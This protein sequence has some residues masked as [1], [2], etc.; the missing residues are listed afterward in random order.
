MQQWA[1]QLVLAS[2]AVAEEEAVVVTEE[3][4]ES[5]VRRARWRVSN[6]RVY[7]SG[8]GGGGGGG[9]GSCVGGAVLRYLL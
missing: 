3:A 6:S 7:G 9:V 2:V 4:E 8:N 1:A 5:T